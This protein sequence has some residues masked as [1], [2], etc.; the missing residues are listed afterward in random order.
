[1]QGPQT[2]AVLHTLLQLLL[3]FMRDSVMLCVKNHD[4]V[5][6][7]NEGHRH[8]AIFTRFSMHVCRHINFCIYAALLNVT[9]ACFSY[10][11]TTFPAARLT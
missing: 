2:A 5:V 1:M 11:V 7:T 8:L 9:T 10:L 6:P 4:I 3:S